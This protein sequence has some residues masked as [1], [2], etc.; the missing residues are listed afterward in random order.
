MMTYSDLVSEACVEG[1]ATGREE[2]MMTYIDL[3]SEACVEGIATGREERMMTYIDLVSEACVEG[4][5]TG[6][7]ESL[8]VSETTNLELFRLPLN[9]L[10][11]EQGNMS[12]VIRD[13]LYVVLVIDY[14]QYCFKTTLQ[15]MYSINSFNNCNRAVFPRV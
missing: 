6:R 14:E 11:G 3:V 8:D 1:I 10:P 15:L 12:T 4:I 2:R 7:E 9:H 13:Q 5:A